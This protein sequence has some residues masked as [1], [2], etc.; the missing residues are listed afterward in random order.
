MTNRRNF[1]KGAGALS[2]AGGLGALATLGNSKA[3]AADTTG[4]KA[5]VCLF[6]FGGQD[7]HDTMLPYDQ[8]SYDRYAQIRSSMIGS[9][10]GGSRDRANLLPLNPTNAAQFGSRQFALPPNLGPIKSL[11]DAGNA[12]VVSNIGP[13]LS[14]VTKT[15]IQNNFAVAPKQLFSHN[16]QQSTWMASAPEGA[17]FGWGGKFADEMIAASANTN[18][19]FTAISLFG[20]S[21]F[22]SGDVAQQ[23]QAGLNG[24]ETIGG[25]DDFSLLGAGSESTVAQALLQEHYRTTGT[26]RSSLFE[27][28]YIA[29]NNRA[30]DTNELYN[31]SLATGT[32]LSTVFP[33]TGIAK[34][35]NAVANTIN[36]R[37]QL[38]VRRQVFFVGM[39]G[40]DSHSGQA[41][42]LPNR[43]TM[44]ADAIASF[45]D[46]MV[47]MGL[48]N[49]VTLFTASDFGR[50]LVVN[51]DGTDHG[52][53]SNHFVV[54]GAVNGN[55]I[56]GD[57]PDYDIDHDQ[58]LGNG[59]FIP[60]T[61]VEQYAAT[62]GEWFGLDSGELA[63]ALPNLSSFSPT[64]LG[65]L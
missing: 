46:A 35:L 56:Y 2:F 33:T 43:Q 49:S 21:V 39:G 30:L 51:G 37:N 61:S 23:Y 64:T 65:F 36:I 13:L 52:W 17:Q 11:F 32:A 45:Y 20:N 29:G 55:T 4:Y 31:D 40:F 57:V 58:D 22:L 12:A 41:G 9:Y 27:R 59:R 50:T 7:G 6:L 26:T 38:N 47:E 63:T 10:P 42:F 18:P 14:P 1:L 24:A 8:A 48:A 5:L 54:G 44:Y 53:A 60:T 19:Q 15:E 28:D 25:L 16:D 62:M 34:Q 3:Y